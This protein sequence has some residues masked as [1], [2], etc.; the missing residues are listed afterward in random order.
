M[1]SIVPTPACKKADTCETHGDDFSKLSDIE[2]MI[3]D[4]LKN[5]RR[6]EIYMET[7]AHHK[8]M[9]NTLR[10]LRATKST[11]CGICTC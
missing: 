7:S 6:L 11:P 10:D 4:T 5:N 1:L 8:K 2:R 3:F 9:T